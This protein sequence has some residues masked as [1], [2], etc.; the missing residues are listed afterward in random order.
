MSVDR[1]IYVFV[2][3]ETNFPMWFQINSIKISEMSSKVVL[4][5]YIVQRLS[6]ETRFIL[7]QQKLEP[8]LVSTLSEPNEVSFGCFMKLKNS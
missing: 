1:Q 3:D 6:Y 5:S 7:K 8:K 2:E 4:H